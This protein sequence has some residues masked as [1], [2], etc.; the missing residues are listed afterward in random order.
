MKFRVFPYSD[1][2]PQPGMLQKPITRD[3]LKKIYFFFKIEKI[4]FE[5]EKKRKVLLL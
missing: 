1:L 5:K 3:L 2:Y 4:E